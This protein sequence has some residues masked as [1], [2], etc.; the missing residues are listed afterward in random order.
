MRRARSPIA[1]VDRR[2]HKWITKSS[3]A[4]WPPISTALQSCPSGQG[5]T[6]IAIVSVSRPST[7]PAVG[8]GQQTLGKGQHQG[9]Q[10]HGM[11]RY[12]ATPLETAQGA[13]YPLYQWLMDLPGISWDFG[14]KGC[15]CPGAVCRK[16]EDISSLQWDTDSSHR[17][18]RLF[19]ASVPPKCVTDLGSGSS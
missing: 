12:P 8:L 16:P 17:F 3:P 14:R 15:W 9:Q 6:S 2:R 11:G 7:P 10:I 4:S 18:L 1:K 5:R 13:N 19:G